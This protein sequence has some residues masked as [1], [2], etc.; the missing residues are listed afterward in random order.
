MSYPEVTCWSPLKQPHLDWLRKHDVP[1]HALLWPEPMRWAAGTI[2]K[3]GRFEEGEGEEH[4]VFP[5]PEDVVFWRP[6]TDTLGTW[7]RRIF[8]LGA[9]AIDNPGTFALDGN[10][11]IFPSPLQWL[12]AKRDGIVVLDWSLAFD[13]LRDCP[14]VAVA[15]SLLPQYRRHMQPARLPKIFVI[16]ERRAAA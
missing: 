7:H 13:R 15:E 2:A 12:Q 4:L 1:L 5:E 10:L 9:E 16:S 3:D 6:G 8:A 14:R 11:N